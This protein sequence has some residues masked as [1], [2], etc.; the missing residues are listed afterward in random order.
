MFPLIYFSLAL[1]NNM[2][3]NKKI[4]II[5]ISA[6][7]LFFV[8]AAVLLINS[9]LSKKSGVS[10]INNNGNTTTPQNGSSV[11][12]STPPIVRDTTKINKM[13]KEELDK[14]R[15]APVADISTYK[16]VNEC[17]KLFKSETDKNVCVTLWSE[18][19]KDP[20]LCSKATEAGRKICE[21]RAWSAKAVTEKNISVCVNVKSE[22]MR[23]TC[24]LRTVDVAGLSKEAC[25]PLPDDE[26]K[27]CIKRALILQAKNSAGCE[28][29]SD[30]DIKQACHN[31]YYADIV[32]N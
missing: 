23:V 20:N 13:I 30:L 15:N 5:V 18:Y 25:Q 11:V 29:I 16:D 8:L 32:R 17:T 31:N 27:V 4:L 6:L 2:N 10:K 7:I 12:S 19:K 26:A 28:N 3:K 22:G 14:Y 9:T 21:D 1:N 24:I